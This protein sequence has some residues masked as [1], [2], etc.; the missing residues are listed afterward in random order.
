M[1]KCGN[2]G[3]RPGRVVPTAGIAPPL[4]D[5]RRRFRVSPA[6]RPARA[7]RR[8]ERRSA[9]NPSSTGCCRIS[10]KRIPADCNRSALQRLPDAAHR[11]DERAQHSLSFLP[12]ARQ[13]RSRSTCTR[14]IG[15]MYGLRNMIERCT[16]GSPSSKRSPPRT[17]STS[18]RVRSYSARSISTNRRY[19]LV[20][21]ALVACRNAEVG[22]SQCQLDVVDQVGE[23]K[24]VVAHLA[25]Q[26]SPSRSRASAS[27][28]PAPIPAGQHVA[29]LRPRVHPGNRA[30]RLDAPAAR[31]AKSAASR[32]ACARSRRSASPGGRS[33]ELAR[34][35]TPWRR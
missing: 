27:A 22:A 21:Q 19:L 23:E 35:R 29:T 2:T 3:A 18:S 20:D 13:R 26:R 16:V 11:R 17:L 4:C 12:P 32:S 30:Q 10:R 5:R 33:R 1:T 9:T 25:Q 6:A 8:T 15:S 31:C 24:P 7:G 14:C 34:P 28:L